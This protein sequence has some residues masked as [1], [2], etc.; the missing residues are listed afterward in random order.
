M[1]QDTKKGLTN[2]MEVAI[3][4]YGKPPATPLETRVRRRPPPALPGCQ[5]TGL[6]SAVGGRRRFASPN[7]TRHQ[8]QPRTI[9][10]VVAYIKAR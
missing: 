6:R 9:R 1:L 3:F 7:K 10:E 2:F 5:K 4:E 8:L